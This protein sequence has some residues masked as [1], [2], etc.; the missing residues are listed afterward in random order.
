MLVRNNVGA[1]MMAT[2]KGVFVSRTSMMAETM[3]IKYGVELARAEGFQ[4]LIVG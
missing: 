2:T 3:A 1:V 4:E